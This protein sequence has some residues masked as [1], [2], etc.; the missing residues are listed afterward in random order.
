[1]NSKSRTMQPESS[2]CVAKSL[3]NHCAFGVSDEPVSK[4]S[5]IREYPRSVQWE[6]IL[7]ERFKQDR[8]GPRG[9]MSC[10]IEPVL[11]K[12]TKAFHAAN[13]G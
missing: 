5:K 7:G 8:K 3:G 13:R 12:S 6:S 10:P 4:P 11:R 1:M 2:R 9:C